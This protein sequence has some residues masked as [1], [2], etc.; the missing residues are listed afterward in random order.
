MNTPLLSAFVAMLACSPALRAQTVATGENP[1]A[2][3]AAVELPEA[4]VRGALVRH[5][6]RSDLYVVTPELRRGATSVFD[7][8]SRLPGVDYNALSGEVSVR[9]SRSVVI[10]IDGVEA[11]ADELQALPPERLSKIELIYAPP[12]RYA[13]SGT[14]YVIAVKRKSDYVGHELYAGN[15]AMLSA[16]DNNG[17]HPLANEQPS[18]RYVYS[19]EKFDLSAGYAFA[20]IHWNYPLSLNRTYNG[21]ASIASALVSEKQP[22]DL[23]ATT[24]H[25]A[26][27]G[28]DWHINP[29]QTL[30]FRTSF[31]SNDIG[32]RTIFD[33]SEFDP[34]GN[35]TAAYTDLASNASKSAETTAALFYQGSLNDYWNIYAALGYDGLSDRISATYETAG[36]A[37]FMPY[38]NKK[39]Y[40]RYELDLTRALGQTLSLNFGYRG[41]MNEYA[42]RHRLTGA[43]LTENDEHRHN[44]YAFIDWMPL[45]NLMLHAGA[46]L[47]ALGSTSLTDERRYVRFLPQ[48]TATWVASEKVQLLADFNVRPEYPTLEMV[49]EAPVAEDKWLT[50]SGN[51]ALQSG[52]RQSISLQGAFFGSLI[53]GAEYARSDNAVTDWYEQTAATAFR[54]TFINAEKE[55]FGAMAAYDWRI[56]PS[57]TWSNALLWSRDRIAGGGRSAHAANLTCQSAL[58]WWIAPIKLTARA[59]YARG[60][61]KVPQLQGF[62]HYEQ[63]LWQI[64]LKRTFLA[65]RLSVSLNYVPPIHAG[66]RTVQTSAIHT[67]SCA[68]Q[69]A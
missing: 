16:G 27:L 49:A 30:S 39:N 57:L 1:P 9:M 18:A 25:T 10:E 31:L 42:T 11:S 45:P 38:K 8:L 62:S 14:R 40:W 26:R 50:Y 53:I 66:V 56:T 44:A 51:A 68:S 29:K 12:A 32:R 17:R 54:R 41:V 19:G 13:A 3:S 4:V 61:K 43:K 23:N 24:A 7:V 46:G 37:S 55:T 34:A 47:E 5:D 36:L 2:D 35:A 65:D 20:D 63:D 22:N 15:F 59:D 52:T 6:A 60:M 28:L 67:P 48:L 64:S 69:T 33:L 58:E 21:A